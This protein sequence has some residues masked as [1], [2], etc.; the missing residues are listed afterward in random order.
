[1][2][3]DQR[4]QD[5]WAML[6]CREKAAV[7]QVPM[8]VVFCL[9]PEFQGATAPQYRFMAD[10]L[11]QV[12]R[13]LVKL[14]IPFHLLIGKPE[15]EVPAFLEKNQSGLLITDF[16]PLR[17]KKDWK[18]KVVKKIRIPFL[19]VDAH[20]VIPCWTASGKQE[21]AAYTIRPKIEKRLFTFLEP[22]PELKKHPFPAGASA[23]IS[24][25]WE[26]IEKALRKM[27][28][29][30]PVS[31]DSGEKEALN[32]MNRFIAER[33]NDYASDRNDP[34]KHGI[35]DLSPYLHFGQISAQRVALEIQ[36]ADANIESKDAFLEE[37]IVRRELSDN[38]CHYNAHYDQ[39]GGF[40]DWAK[41][42]IAAHRRDKRAY[43]YS[44]EQFEQARTHEALWNACQ[45]EMINTGKMHGYMR[46]YWAKKILEWTSS[47]EEAMEIA[48]TLNDRYELDGRDPNGYTGIAWAIGGVHDRAWFERPVFGKIR[49]MNENGARKKFDVD[50][51]IRSHIPD[52]KT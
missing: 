20:N 7:Y 27:V 4:A 37:L 19:E 29:G 41:K 38:F 22:F 39:T 14:N 6:A 17:I 32:T 1:M 36:D 9:V 11:K 50:R 21:F 31:F 45:M 2:S 23:E 18:Q 47:A 35:S 13:D 10:G 16:D 33:L 12:E 15:N 26:R 28:S 40:P 52:M 5:N 24:N 8:S 25:D 44:L 48:I 30:Q 43:L 3:R 51:Y 46:M 42:T 34:T 49:Y